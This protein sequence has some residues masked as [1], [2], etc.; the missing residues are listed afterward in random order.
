MKRTN[1]ML[2]G[3]GLILL[4]LLL[5]ALVIPVSAVV[6]LSGVFGNSMVLQC[7]RSI[8]IWGWADPG[9]NVYIEFGKGRART[10]ADAEGKWMVKLSATRPGGP[11]SMKVKGKNSIQL[12]DVLVGEVWICSGQSNM[13]W[14]L[15]R[16]KDAEL[17]IS[18]ANFPKIRLFDVPEEPAGK[19]ATDVDAVWKRCSPDTARSF[20]AVAYFFGGSF[21][22]S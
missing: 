2:V 13:K 18:V 14:P 15:E 19:P 20:S 3:Y 9:E 4:M 1:S 6:R 11:F 22:N 16:A 10:Q 12:T 17:E 21:T 8:P 5:F 7:D